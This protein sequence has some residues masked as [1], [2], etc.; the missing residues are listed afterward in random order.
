M[1]IIDYDMAVQNTIDHLISSISKFH[2][3]NSDCIIR[4]LLHSPLYYP[5]IIASN[6]SSKALSVFHWWWLQMPGLTRSFR[7]MWFFFYCL[8]SI[9]FFGLYSINAEKHIFCH[10][11]YLT[12]N[13]CTCRRWSLS[14]LTALFPFTVSPACSIGEVSVVKWEGRSHSCKEYPYLIWCYLTLT[15][16]GMSSYQLALMVTNPL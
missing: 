3:F 11:K 8:Y 7:K 6:D 2:L 1:V 14:V 5:W 12:P 10:L 4:K 13:D 16:G 15:Q 9:Y